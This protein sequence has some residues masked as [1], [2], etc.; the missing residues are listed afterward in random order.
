MGQR[1][2]YQETPVLPGRPGPWQDREGLL[3]EEGESLGSGDKLQP[4]E[5]RRKQAGEWEPPT[6]GEMLQGEGKEVV[7][8]QLGLPQGPEKEQGWL[9]PP[10]EQGE[11]PG[12]ALQGSEGQQRGQLSQERR[13]LQGENQG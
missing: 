6:G 1:Q 7:G 5:V 13:E 8:E 9:R 3:Q 4:W 11:G 2:G 10:Q 12:A